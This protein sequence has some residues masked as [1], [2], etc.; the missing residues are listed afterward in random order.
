[1]YNEIGWIYHLN[2]VVPFFLDTRQSII[3]YHCSLQLSRLSNA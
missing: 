2:H 1:M 3:D